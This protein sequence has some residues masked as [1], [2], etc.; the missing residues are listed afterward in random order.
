MSVEKTLYPLR[1][2]L[3]NGNVAPLPEKPGG[4]QW[5]DDEYYKE[6]MAHRDQP[7]ETKDR[8]LYLNVMPELDPTN[9]KEGI[10]SLIKENNLLEA[11]FGTNG[12]RDFYMG[13]LGRFH[14][15]KKLKNKSLLQLEEMLQ[16][17][18]GRGLI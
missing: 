16:D 11:G 7:I 15:F 5:Y 8:K 3:K 10:L 2:G 12:D 4:P 17:L 1:R 14:S 6:K 13:V 9:L 18:L